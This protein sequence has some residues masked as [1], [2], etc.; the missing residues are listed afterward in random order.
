LDNVNFPTKGAYANLN[1]ALSRPALG[2]D[3][4]YDR[5]N[6]S[7][8]FVGSVRRYTVSARAT[9][10]ILL[11]REGSV[12]NAARLGG[13][14]N[15]SGFN[16][17]ELTGEDAALVSV[18]AYRRFGRSLPYYLGASFEMGNVWTVED[19][20]RDVDPIQAGSLFA[21]VDTFLGPVIL[22]FGF[23]EESRSSLYLNIGQAF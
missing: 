23:A 16:Q 17:N 10:S 14:L 13:F 9:A 18:V 6:S 7:L 21:G 11:R 4:I 19:H 1:Y 22:A 12:E 5:L 2:A 8:I 20:F 15:L 3:K